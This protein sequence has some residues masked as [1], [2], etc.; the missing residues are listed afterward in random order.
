MTLTRENFERYLVAM[1]G[2]HLPDGVPVPSFGRALT[3][4]LDR[5]EYCFTRIHRKYF[6]EGG[7]NTPQVTLDHLNGDHM[8]AF[9]YFLSNSVY[10]ESADARLATK[11]FYLNKVLHGLDA[12]FSVELP[13]IFRL[14]HPVGTVLGRAA[15]S[16][17]LMVYQNCGVGA[18]EDGIYPTFGEGVILYSRSSVLGKCRIG[19]DVVIGAN[20]FVLNTDVPDNTVVVGQYPHTKLIQNTRP[21]RLRAFDLG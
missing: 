21:V 8:A 19:R 12:Y 11:L 17:Y 16:D 10:V 15:Y 2:T 14:V 9:L 5:T 6:N 3:L 13:A 7:Q 20:S 4:A 18:D 1:L